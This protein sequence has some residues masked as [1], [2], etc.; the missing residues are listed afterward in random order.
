VDQQDTPVVSNDRSTG[1]VLMGALLVAAGAALLIERLGAMP[2]M[3]RNSIWPVLLI[4]YGL[5][6]L[7][8]P[9]RQ[10]REGLFFVLAGGWWLAGLS[11][12]ISLERT[13]PLLFVALGVSIIL[14]SVTAGGTDTFEAHRLGRRH[15]GGASWILLAILIGAGVTSGLGRHTLR[16]SSSEAGALR[17]YSILGGV[18]SRMRATTLTGGEVVSIMGGSAIDLRDVTIAPGDTVT[19]DVFTL[20]G[21]GAIRVPDE[22]IVDMQAV[23]VMGG[24]KDQ[25]IPLDRRQG[26]EVEPGAAVATGPAPR[27]VVRGAIIMGQLTIKS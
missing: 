1:R 14:Q 27:L 18:N 21:G 19:L 5:A 15:S 22:W 11:G 3:W 25:R 16:E 2:P 9:S 12:S 17:V 7:L 23:P 10:G 8:Q 24:T 13:W 4:G 26:A 6:R 20:M